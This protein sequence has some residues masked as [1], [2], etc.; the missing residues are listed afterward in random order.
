[1]CR[2]GNKN[3]ADMMNK[4]AIDDRSD[5]ALMDTVSTKRHSFSNTAVTGMRRLTWPWFKRHI[6]AGGE[7][8]EMAAKYWKR[9][10]DETGK[11]LKSYVYRG[12][13]IAEMEMASGVDENDTVA[14]D[15]E[16]KGSKVRKLGKAAEDMAARAS[17]HR[18]ERA[19]LGSAS[20]E[21][22]QDE[23]SE[24]EDSDPGSAEEEE[25]EEEASEEGSDPASAEEEEE[26]EE[27]DADSS[28][29]SAEEEEE[30]EEGSEVQEEEEEEEEEE[31]DPEVEP[32]E[33]LE[34]EEEEEETV[35]KKGKGSKLRP[36]H[37]Q[38]AKHRLRAKT[39]VKA[40]KPL[41]VTPRS[42]GKGK[43]GRR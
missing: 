41:S 11:K 6:I 27:E 18:W 34:E 31:E 37:S 42:G 36:G 32:M 38:A 7:D 20:E 29:E 40:R 3:A 23:E 5:D 17:S 15:F 28:E 39:P 14:D 10:T 1:M 35:P 16:I 8:E 43:K 22:S 21:E 30:E 33:G 12:E 26:E 9:C 13:K 19:N 25:E 4:F 24:E 2:K